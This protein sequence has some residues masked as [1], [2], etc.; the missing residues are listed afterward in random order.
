MTYS[1][2]STQGADYGEWEGDSKAEALLALHREAGYGKD[3]VW[4][5]DGN[6]KF[7]SYE[8]RQLIGGVDDWH[9]EAIE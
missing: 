1:I 8:Y 7:K 9:V 2:S 6:L 4:L 5:E 3:K